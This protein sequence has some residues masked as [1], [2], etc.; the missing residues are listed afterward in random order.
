MDMS[1]HNFVPDV[2]LLDRVE[3][4]GGNLLG[5]ISETALNLGNL[6]RA[7][8]SYLDQNAITLDP[9]SRAHLARTR[10]ALNQLATKAMKVAR[11]R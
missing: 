3:P 5:L 9:G 8:E 2:V 1:Q 10:D 11:T 7:I 4:T 6:E